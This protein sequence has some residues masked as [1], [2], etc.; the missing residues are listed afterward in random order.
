MC[1]MKLSWTNSKA[2]TGWRKYIGKT[3]SGQPKCFYLGRS[4]DEA[5]QLALRLTLAYKTLLRAGGAGWTDEMAKAAQTDQ[6]LVVMAPA[7]S[8]LPQEAPPVAIPALSNASANEAESVVVRDSIMLHKAIGQYLAYEERRAPS[9]VTYAHLYGVRTRVKRFKEMVPDQPL[10]A[11]DYDALARLVARFASRP[12]SPHTGKRWGVVT[13]SDMIKGS[14][15]MFDWF[16]LSGRWEAPRRFERIFRVKRRS[17][18]TPDERDNEVQGVET[19]SVEELTRIVEMAWTRWHRL[20]ILTALNLAMTQA[21]LSSIKRRH[22][23]GLDTDHPYIEKC[24]EKTTIF[25]RWGYL[26]PEV[27][28]GLRWALTTHNSQ[29]VFL[30]TA[31]KPPVRFYRTGRA[32]QVTSWW[33]RLVRR[34]NVRPLTFR[35]LRKTGA[36]MVRKLSDRDTSEAMLAHSNEGVSKFYTNHDWEKLADA[37]RLLR[38]QL[39]P[40]FHVAQARPFIPRRRRKPSALSLNSGA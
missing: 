17:M 25:C 21:E 40:L 14:R 10:A 19:F 7:A 1:R 12:V 5:E 4:R 15:S 28:E 20:F 37:L 11:M 23:I 6:P 8:P 32:D 24:R 26:F 31:G 34:A 33:F 3:V 22:I 18:Q 38:E 13:A 30:T 39:D 35:Y 2:Y 29:T 9:Q 16:D 27:A 36:D